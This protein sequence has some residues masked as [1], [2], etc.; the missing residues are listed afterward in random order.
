MVKIIIT[1]SQHIVL[2]KI[3]CTDNVHGLT[4]CSAQIAL[5]PPYL[6]KLIVTL[7]KMHGE[8]Y[9]YM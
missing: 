4:N 8:I 9:T 3:T 2:S 5:Q 7:H 6:A 1:K